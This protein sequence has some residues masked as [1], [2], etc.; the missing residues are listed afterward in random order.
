[1]HFDSIKNLPSTLS[2]LTLIQKSRIM[3]AANQLIE[4]GADPQ[5]A[6][7]QVTKSVLQVTPLTINDGGL[8]EMVSYEVIYEPDVIDTHG[9]WM[10]KETLVEAQANYKKAQ[11]SGAVIENLFHLVETSRWTLVDHWIQPEFDVVVQ[12]TGQVIKAGTWV[13][14]V[15]YND[16][17]IWEAKKSGELG[18][19]SLQCMGLTNEETGEIS[20]LNFDIQEE[21][22]DPNDD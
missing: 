19:L 9:N 14:K 10:S 12:Q 13:A 16:L 4:K 21:S 6:L 20:K 8:E 22:E 7:D 5:S 11:L 3:K 2:N 17:E 15:K 1:M 18:G